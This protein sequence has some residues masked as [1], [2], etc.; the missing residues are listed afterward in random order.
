M[1]S[2]LPEACTFL[3][4]ADLQSANIAHGYTLGA[5]LGYLKPVLRTGKVTSAKR[6]NLTA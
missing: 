2:Q 5:A 1:W 3:Y 4:N 6:W